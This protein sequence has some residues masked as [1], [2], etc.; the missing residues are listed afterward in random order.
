MVMFPTAK[1]LLGNI[2][3]HQIISYN[4]L[5]YIFFHILLRIFIQNSLN[6]LNKRYIFNC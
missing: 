5:G 2:L 1:G 4:I 3:K 6:T